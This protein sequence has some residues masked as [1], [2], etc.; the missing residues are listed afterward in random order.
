MEPNGFFGD[1]SRK[2]SSSMNR[3]LTKPITE[4]KIK[5][6]VF[7]IN[8]LGAPGDDG[9]TAKFYQFFWYTIKE[10]VGRAVRSFFSKGRMLR[11]FNHT[12]ICLIP[13]V[14]KASSMAQ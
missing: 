14:Q 7:S 1:L 12:Q 6:A 13:K 8:P 2:V 3:N 9:F 5:R 4:A 10:D 11:S